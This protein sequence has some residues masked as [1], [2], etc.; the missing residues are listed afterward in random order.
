MKQKLELSGEA[1]VQAAAG[2]KLP[3]F[4]LV[5]YTGAA[6]RQHWSESPI[7]VDLAGVQV[8]A[9]GPVLKGH[10]TS[11]GVGHWTASA[12]DG[13]QLSI[14]GVFSRDTTEAREI[15]TSGARGYP[16]KVSIGADILER[17]E[18]NEGQATVNG[19]VFDAPLII[20]ARSNVYEVSF[21]ELAADEATSAKIAA[22]RTKETPDMKT[23]EQIQA[24]KDE[25]AKV[26]AKRVA[27]EA[28][29]KAEKDAKDE[30]DRR[31]KAQR[32][33]DAGE[34]ARV[35]AIRAIP[36]ITAARASKAILDG[37]QADK[38]ELEVLR[39][40][41]PAGFNV[42]IGQRPDLTPDVMAAAVC[43]TGGLTTG[44]KP[45]ILEAA[46]KG[47]G[48]SISLQQLI[49]ECARLS[50]YSGSPY[51]RTAG[52]IRD[53]IRA[54][55]STSTLASVLSTA[56]NRFLM[57]AFNAVDS[58]WREIASIN[59]SVQDFREYETYA[60]TG[61]L[62]FEKLAP[63]GKIKHG[64][65]DDTK[66]TNQVDTYARMLQVSRKDIINDDIGIIQS[67]MRKLGRGGALALN[68]AF[69]TEFLLNTGD[70]FG[71]VNGNLLTGAGSA[72][73]ETGLTGAV[74]AFREM[75]GPDA[76][77]VMARIKTLLVPPALEVPA[78]NWMNSTT[79]VGGTSKAP[80]NNPFAGLAT[81]QTSPYLKA[82]STKWWLIADPADVPVIE[83]GFLRGA[84]NPTVEEV[85]ADSDELGIA[86]RGYF[87]F[88][89]KKQVPQA[90]VQSNG[91]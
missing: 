39:A 14:S 23:P 2:D 4:D 29:A 56:A 19:R 72:F 88:G 87:D 5:A 9:S 49:V 89:V 27:D 52:D 30:A 44:F 53:A 83:V 16:W 43:A 86:M 21:V 91:V 6:L 10:T 13:K 3:T 12:N 84:Q 74:K 1:R 38:V 22:E 60:W 41:R 85:D 42:S 7:V 64:V 26:E 36:G 15:A 28:T 46:N 90:A 35:D 80:G 55:F 32:A 59:P 68:T 67:G 70:F 76:N 20:V 25:A 77:Y 63:A 79:V 57:E 81:V 31:L 18:V 66:Y 50:G 51:L 48:K 73:G 65:A 78:K 37:E 69:W 75:V 45:E 24:E 61:D 54:A 40:A 58:V 62:A 34:V 33:A 17:R 71:T 11:Q 47:F 8:A 82:N